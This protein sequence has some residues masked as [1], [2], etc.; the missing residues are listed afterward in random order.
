M[1][2]SSKTLPSPGSHIRDLRRPLIDSDRSPMR[3]IVV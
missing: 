3:E 2:A 1:R